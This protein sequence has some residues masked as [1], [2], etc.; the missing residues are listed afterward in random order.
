MLP[1]L[2]SARRTPLLETRSLSVSAPRP[3]HVP[4]PHGR[5]FAKSWSTTA[6]GWGERA[7]IILF[8]DSLGSIDLWRDFPGQLA[9]AT[10]RAVIAYDRLGFGGSDP[11]PGALALDFVAD[12]AKTYVPAL[13]AHLGIHRFVACGHS[14]GGGMAVET[15]ALQPD[16][17]LA[18]VTLGAQAFAED[19]TLSGIRVAKDDFAKPENLARLARYHGEKAAWVVN[20]WTESWLSPA[21]ADW[22]IDT[23]LAA[24]RCPVLAIHGENDEYGSTVHPHRIATGRG[25]AHVLGGVGHVPHREDPARVLALIVPFLA[26]I[27]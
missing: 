23:A 26:E 13:L 15:A 21:F 25:S 16:D 8:H 4:T 24:V 14:V 2:P 6:D 11:H 7:P 1:S 17:C 3:W 27:D 5:L 20:A 18:V 12:E 19:R 10:G 22:T 9:Q